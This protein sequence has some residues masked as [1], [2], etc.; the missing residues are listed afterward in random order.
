MHFIKWLQSLFGRKD[1]QKLRET[2]EQIIEDTDYGE[3]SLHHEEK[4]LIRNLLDLREL[5]AEDVMIPRSEVQA[6]SIDITLEDALKFLKNEPYSRYPIY[7]DNL[8]DMRG[9]IYAKDLVQYVGRNDF[10]CEKILKKPL[11]VPTTIPILDLLVK[12]RQDK[13]PMAV[14]IDEFGGTDGIITPWDILQ[15]ILGDMQALEQEEA[16]AEIQ[17]LTSTIAVVDGRLP[18]EDFTKAFAAKLT[19]DEEEEN[20]E[21]VNGL[22]LYLAGRVPNR[23]EIIA[24]SSGIEFEIV[25]ATPRSVLKVKIIHSKQS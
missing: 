5:R 13:I 20:I 25:E 18:I 12:M 8:D 21:T 19:E 11:L 9:F 7:G 10:N 4:E 23:A 16:I 15:E 2:L 14:V 1:K 3:A 6:M 24:H 22:I 17:H